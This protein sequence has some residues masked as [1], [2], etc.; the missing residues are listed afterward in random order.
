MQSIGGMSVGLPGPKGAHRP[1]DRFSYI[2]VTLY[3]QNTQAVPAELVL[4]LGC[5][6]FLLEQRLKINDRKKE[7]NATFHFA[8]RF[9]RHRLAG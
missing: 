7:G 5:L 6:R 2:A 1:C 8:F 4:F 9:G 3:G